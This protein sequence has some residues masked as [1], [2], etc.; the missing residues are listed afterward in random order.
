MYIQIKLCTSK[1]IIIKIK[2]EIK[3]KIFTT[4]TDRRSIHT[5]DLEEI[6]RYTKISMGNRQKT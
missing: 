3:Q 2:M 6:M 5:M 1:N 4:T